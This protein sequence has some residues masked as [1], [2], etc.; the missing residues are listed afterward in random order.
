MSALGISALERRQ[1]HAPRPDTVRLLADALEL[2]GEER[3]AFED[4]A[5]AR[6]RVTAEPEH[7]SPR[8]A[9]RLAAPPTPLI[10]RADEI[11]QAV[12]LLRRED[13]RLLTLVGPA[14]VGKSRLGLAVA[15]AICT[16][17]PDGVVLVPL[18]SLRDPALVAATISQ[19]LG[20]HE[21]GD[22]PLEELL[23]A[24]LR[25]KRL[26][27]LLDNVEHLVAAA[28]LLAGLLAACPQLTLLL[29]SRARLHVR[30]E[31]ALPV[32]PLGL[33]NL[34]ADSPLGAL[35]RAPAVALFVERAAACPH[36]TSLYS[37][38]TRIHVRGEDA[39]PKETVVLPDPVADK[40]RDTLLQS[41]AV[42]L[43]VE[44]AQA[45]DPCFTLTDANAASVAEICRR[46]DGLPLAI[47]LAA[48]RITLLPP[49]ALL[50]RLER[51]L[52]LLVGGARDLP[53]RQR[54]LRDAV[55]W[56]ESLISTTER[57]LLRRLSLFMGGATLEALEAVCGVGNGAEADLLAWL[58]A[59]VE[60]NLVRRTD[61]ADGA[62][63]FDL[64]ETIREYA[65]ELLAASGEREATERAYAAY[66]TALAEEAEAAL[67]GPE[68]GIW[69][70]R[71][72]QEQDNLRAALQ[73][74]LVS[75]RR[76]DQQRR[77]LA[78]RMTAS[79]WR[80]WRVR[81]H[82]SEGRRWLAAAL[83]PCGDPVSA[84]LRIRALNGA[85]ILARLQLDHIQARALCMESLALAR[86]CGDVV[87][88]ATALSTLG[89]LE[90]GESDFGHA[91]ALFEEALALYRE[92]GDRRGT[93]VL[94][95]QLGDV[96][97][98]QGD[99]RRARRLYEDSL[100]L[101]RELGDTQQRAYRLFSL[102]Y[103][104]DQQGDSGH[105][106]ALYAESLALFREL[107]DRQGITSALNGL[108][109]RILL[110]EQDY[111]RAQSYFEEAL[112]IVRALGDQ[113]NLARTLAY[114]GI[115]ARRR[116]DY[117]QASSLLR[118]SL[119]LQRHLGGH[120]PVASLL[121]EFAALALAQQHHRRAAQ[122]YAVAVGLS[123]GVGNNL[124]TFPHPL[125]QE[126]IARVRAMLGEEV[127]AAA[128]AAGR[129][130][131]LEEGI[132]LALTIQPGT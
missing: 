84:A 29:T 96:A 130:M 72:E 103:A 33:P 125:V 92:L 47:E 121:K 83:A 38:C 12:A 9:P 91:R 116:G 126:E 80:F 102:A 85:A 105:A 44:R 69:L 63:R 60:Q 32:E 56:S 114:L 6:R 86:A 46:L 127:F 107:R 81:G 67:T 89:R 100:A 58:Q 40:P 2:E 82:V 129:A 75:D 5:R 62:P 122:L 128:W 43:F 73:W 71:L 49:P 79:L 113:W 13:V 27:L 93:A 21:E 54:T 118:E 31:Y 10:G 57:A 18:A 17:Y 53:P 8:S 11:A 50:E 24:W 70:D 94:L 64:L 101:S 61:G 34:A 119:V 52:P 4:A 7:A 48:D 76:P 37:S 59:L 39:V 55:A 123:E 3:A 109:M 74:T 19:A 23:I 120:V 42:A 36:L 98:G 111:V 104:E 41:P 87:G 16:G 25:R 115:V 14:G 117:P 35:P 68:R 110:D 124:G 65:G 132:A 90:A 1:R 88:C 78:L 97:R 30:G 95:Q 112:P 28:P 22:R 45:V 106:R 108:G 131:S 77:E 26:L 20:V 66:Y 51:R 15:E 99:S